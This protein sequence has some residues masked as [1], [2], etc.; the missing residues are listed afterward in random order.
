MMPKPEGNVWE[1][2][3]LGRTALKTNDKN[4]SN[5]CK[6]SGE[7]SYS[8]AGETRSCP[9]SRYEVR[10]CAVWGTSRNKEVQNST[11]DTIS[12]SRTL[13]K[14]FFS[15]PLK[16]RLEKKT[17]LRDSNE[18]RTNGTWR[19]FCDSSSAGN[20]KKN[21]RRN[22]ADTRDADNRVNS[23]GQA[24]LQYVRMILFKLRPESSHCVA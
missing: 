1:S 17:G 21:Q 2:R 10:Q 12:A 24:H 9:N 15:L 22:I 19:R 4:C 20:A 13:S 23:G 6:I 5:R 16:I 11:W 14:S 3:D 8:S 18:T 7:R